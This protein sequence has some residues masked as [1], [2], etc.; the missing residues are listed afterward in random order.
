M[1]KV[2]YREHEQQADLAG[3]SVAEVRELFNSEFS[4]PDRAG[5]SLNGKQLKRKLEPETKLGDEDKLS[6]EEKGG[7]GLVLFGALLL[8][9]AITG[10]IFAYTATTDTIGIVVT[11]GTTDYAEVT[12]NTTPIDPY[13]IIGKIR[14]TIAPGNMFGVAGAPEYNGDVEVIVALTNVDEMM[15]DYSFWLVRLQFTDATGNTPQDEEQST[16][17]LSLTSPSASFAVTSGNF[18]PG[19]VYLKGGSYRALPASLWGGGDP[20]DPLIYCE[21][22]QASTH[23]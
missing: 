16:Q 14:G 17:I 9:L 19:Y 2:I 10:G 8:T 7:K 20:A 5:A 13:Q 4:I 23:P 21:V 12:A 15:D 18:S 11:A 3:K 6:F 22:V 1:V